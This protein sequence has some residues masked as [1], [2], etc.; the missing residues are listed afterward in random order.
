MGDFTCMSLQADI[1]F[2]LSSQQMGL[3]GRDK[4]FNV[5]SVEEFEMIIKHFLVWILLDVGGWSCELL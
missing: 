1:I 5:S 3:L 2:I 4:N